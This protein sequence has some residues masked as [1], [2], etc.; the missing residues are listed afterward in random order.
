MSPGSV[1]DSTS[2]STSSTGN[3]HGWVV[4][5]GWLFLTLGISHTSEGFLPSGL[6]D[7]SPAFG[8]LKWRLF[9]YLDG[10]RMGSRCHV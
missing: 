1:I 8:P 9:G 3:W 10:T 4:F 7:N 5:S 6:P 2:R